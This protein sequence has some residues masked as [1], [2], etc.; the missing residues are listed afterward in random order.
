MVGTNVSFDVVAT[1]II[2]ATGGANNG[3]VTSING[4]LGSTVENTGTFLNIINDV[5]EVLEFTI[6]NVSG[7]GAGE[8]LELQN[9]L[10]QNGGSANADQSGGFGGTF[11]QLAVD[12]VTLTS[13][14]GTISVVNQSDDGDLG[15]SLLNNDAGNATTGNTF[16][17]SANNLGFTNSFTVELTDDNTQAVVIQGFQFAV[18]ADPNAVPEPSSALVI[19]GLLGVG[20]CKRRRS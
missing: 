13:D 5:P 3:N 17:H 18:V 14:N 20:V 8:S 12:S 4:G 6:T 7:L 15:V 11:G 16:A 1:A 10:S 19:F 9:L 2:P